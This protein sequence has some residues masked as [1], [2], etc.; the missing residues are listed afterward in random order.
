MPVRA[1][2]VVVDCAVLATDSKPFTTPVTWG[3]NEIVKGAVWPAP[4]VTGR[5]NPPILN[6]ELFVIAAVTVTFAPLATSDPDALPLVPTATLPKSNV[7]G[8]IVS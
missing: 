4:I 7:A 1:A 5:G 6:T 8:L 3:L 2:M